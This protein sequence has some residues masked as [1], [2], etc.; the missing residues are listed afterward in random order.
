MLLV[1][2]YGECWVWFAMA[3]E[4]PDEG[5]EG[6]GEGEEEPPGEDEGA[7]GAVGGDVGDEEEVAQFPIAAIA[8]EVKLSG[9]FEV[10]V[11]PEFEAAVFDGEGDMV[12]LEDSAVPLGD[13]GEGEEEGE[14]GEGEDAEEAAAGH[15]GIIPC[16]QGK[17]SSSL[18]LEVISC[19]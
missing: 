1:G 9:A 4:P 18:H 7:F 6:S 2:G 3:G 10:G 8:D 16:G 19:C 11:G 12:A 13:E 5:G 14:G 15:G 17:F